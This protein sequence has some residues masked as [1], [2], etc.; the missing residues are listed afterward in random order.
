MCFLTELEIPFPGVCIRPMMAK[1]C[2]VCV[3][4]FSTRRALPVT[5]VWGRLSGELRASSMVAKSKDC[6]EEIG[7][8][9]CFAATLAGRDVEVRCTSGRQGRHFVAAAAVDEK[10]ACWV[11]WVVDTAAAAAAA[12]AM[13]AWVGEGR[14]GQ[15][16]FADKLM[17]VVTGGQRRC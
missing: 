15:V 14:M 9:R 13:V 4:S 6:L 12:A 8:R 17:A 3:Q 5:T 11:C 2:V 16:L 10:T 1:L 7:C